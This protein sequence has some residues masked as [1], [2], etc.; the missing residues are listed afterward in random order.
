ME[1]GRRDWARHLLATHGDVIRKRLTTTVD[2]QTGVY[3]G[4]NDAGEKLYALP[5]GDRYRMRFD[6][7]DQSEGYPDFGGDLA[8]V[9]DYRE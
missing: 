6:R 7:R 9:G 1:Q 2:R 5:N 3:A 8:P 4:L